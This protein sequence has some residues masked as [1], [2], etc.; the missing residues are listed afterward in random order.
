MGETSPL[1]LRQYFHSLR[2]QVDALAS[3]TIRPPAWLELERVRIA[4]AQIERLAEPT[5]PLE[6]LGAGQEGV[7]F[8]DGRL[9]F[10]YLDL[11]RTRSTSE[12]R[13]FLRAQIGAWP[14]A[15]CLYPLRRLVEQ[16]QDAILSYAYEPS[17][18]YSGGHGAGLVH[19]LRELQAHGVACRN[20]HPRNLRVVKDR[21]RLIDYGADLMPLDQAEW[22]QMLRRAWLSWRWTHL[23]ELDQL[24]RRALREEPPELNG[25]ERL[26][27]AVQAP[28]AKLDADALTIEMVP[29]SGPAR[30]LDYGCGAGETVHALAKRGMQVVGFDV[31]PDPRW[32]VAPG[33][34]F[35]TDRELALAGARRDVVVCA[36]V[37]CTLDDSAYRR[38][39]EDIRG[40]V[41][42]EGTVVLSVCNPFHT[43]GGDTPFQERCVAHGSDPDRAIPWTKRVRGTGRERHD[44]HRP[45]HVLTRDLMR[46]GLNVESA[47][48]TATVDL[49]RLEPASDFIVLRARAM[50]AGPKVSLLVRTSAMEWRTLALQVRHV[51]EQLEGPTPFYERI[52]VLDSRRARF[53]RQYDEADY[54]AAR[55]VLLS[56][57][58]D[59]VIDRIVFAP[60]GEDVADLTE[61]W[62]AL[63]AADAH[64]ASGAPI[65]SSLTGIEACSGDYILHVDDDLLVARR[66]RD[67]DYLAEMVE[68]LQADPKAV[69]SALNICQAEDQEWSTADGRGPWRVEV[70]CTLLHGARLRA[71]RPWPNELDDGALRRSWHRAL[72]AR[73]Q[74]GGLHSLRGGRA[75]TFFVH[76][77]NDAKRDR[78]A[79]LAILDRM[80][81]GI[82][83]H[84]QIGQVELH[85]SL[86]EWLRPERHEELVIVACGRN[87][88][89]GRVARF[90]ASLEAQTEQDFGLVIVEDG[91]ARVA[92]DAVRRQFTSWSNASILTLRER[93]G[94]LANIVWALRYMCTNPTS[95]VVLIDLDDALL[96]SETLRR[97]REEFEQG[98]DLAVGG[99]RRTD[100]AASYPVDFERPRERRGGNVW[101]HLRC[102]RRE[103]FDRVPDE[104]LRL[105]GEYVD[106]AWDWAL[107]LPLVELASAPR[108]I[109]E[110]LYLHEPSGTGKNPAERRIR[111]DIIAR[112][113][114]KPSLRRGGV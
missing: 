76:P 89:A 7:V 59:R 6:L 83:P 93:R 80:E 45:L 48:E 96:G 51:V 99:M 84:T 2:A 27:Q 78:D 20:L 9:V 41:R 102:F 108:Y 52:V 109:D 54:E 90:R 26:D 32:Q 19:L 67:H 64:S 104:A 57:L 50:P 60:E 73:I 42:D 36:L 110:S 69:C 65:A 68:A 111:E 38:A 40:A 34:S 91:G 14:D 106:L 97:I 62:F 5:G 85:G 56:L 33:A 107:L 10:K 94:A 37:L 98:A 70:R 1:D 63:R 16:E 55:A 86:S 46:A 100:K 79:W 28:N 81:A 39:L 103:L 11:W 74:A 101:Q 75:S 13:A 24:M 58:A 3:Q 21:V 114:A 72:D 30:V 112:I 31:V 92:A 49:D 82:V 61:R 87:V 17:Q 25:W 4:Q 35:T 23:P 66:D 77:P 105:D 29:A 53:L 95:I 71:S 43:Q 44:V 47:T 8:T 22:R 15:Q 18:P 88:P 113:V 12:S